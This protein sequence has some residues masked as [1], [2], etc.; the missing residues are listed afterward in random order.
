[1]ASGIDATAGQRRPDDAP[2]RVVGA[3]GTGA[4]ADR[5][6]DRV[7]CPGHCQIGDVM[8]G[9]LGQRPVLP[10]TGQPRVDEPRIT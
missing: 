4:L 8:P 5:I 9:A 3:D 1:M 6:A 2:Q 10:P 7:Q